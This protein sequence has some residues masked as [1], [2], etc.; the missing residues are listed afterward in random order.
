MTSVPPDD[1]SNGIMGTL[2]GLWHNYFVRTTGVVILPSGRHS[3]VNAPTGSLY[4]FTAVLQA[5]M[6]E[7]LYFWGKITFDI[8][9]QTN[10]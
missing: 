7:I 10:K 1:D 6:K 3:R 8:R 4:A 2:L 5:H 9:L